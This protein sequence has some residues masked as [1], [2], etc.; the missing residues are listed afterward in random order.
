M[1]VYMNEYLKNFKDR[2]KLGSLLGCKPISISNQECIYEYEVNENHFNPNGTLHGGTLF[3]VMDTCQGA[4]I[5]FILDP[6][7]KFAATGTASIR[8]LAPVRSGK[9]FVKTTLL[10][11]NK[12]KYVLSSTAKD[13]GDKIVATL[14]ETWIAIQK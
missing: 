7:Y 6:A 3:T 4:F 12:R 10:E 8:Y 14:E 9:I 11:W 5:H 13:E 2:D 1:S